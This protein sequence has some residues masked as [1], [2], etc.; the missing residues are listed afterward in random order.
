MYSVKKRDGLMFDSGTHYKKGAYVSED[1][2]MTFVSAVIERQPAA[3]WDAATARLASR[4]GKTFSPS[5]PRTDQIINSSK[6][7]LV[8]DVPGDPGYDSD[9][10]TSSSSHNQTS[11]ESSSTHSSGYSVRS[12]TDLRPGQPEPNTLDPRTRRGPMPSPIAV[13]GPAWNLRD[14][15][16][17]NHS[18]LPEDAKPLTIPLSFFD[19]RVNKTGV[20]LGRVTERLI[21]FKYSAKQLYPH[22]EL[23]WAVYNEIIQDLVAHWST[24]PRGDHNDLMV[25][26][27]LPT[28]ATKSFHFSIQVSVL[29]GRTLPSPSRRELCEG[30]SG[31]R[32]GTIQ[33]NE[34]H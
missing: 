18:Q 16:R 28:R 22:K 5:P 12:R 11:R 32:P 31:L 3:E 25:V 20:K 27:L 23:T 26:Q 29:S 30:I 19:A 13:H 24:G 1:N 2:A 14:E 21:P 9:G 6:D 17:S 33:F 8:P 10:S 15:Q 7:A 4:E 34:R